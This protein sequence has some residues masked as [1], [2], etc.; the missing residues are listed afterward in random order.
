LYNKQLAGLMAIA[1]IV[2]TIL[3]GT[4]FSIK[5][6]DDVEF[7]AASMPETIRCSEQAKLVHSLDFMATQDL[8]EIVIRCATLAKRPDIATETTW[9]EVCLENKEAI[10]RFLDQLQAVSGSPVYRRY[11]IETEDGTEIQVIDF[12][13]M[14]AAIG[15]NG[16]LPGCNTIYA[17]ETK[18]GGNVSLYRGVR[19]FF[20]LRHD[21]ITEIECS[22][23]DGTSSFRSPS[24]GSQAVGYPPI[25]DAPMGKMHV[26]N[27]S[28]GDRVHLEVHF[29]TQKLPNYRIVAETPFCHDGIIRLVTVDTGEDEPSIRIDRV[30]PE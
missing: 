20:F 17:V 5:E 4:M 24:M 10:E 27:L 28:S 16:L 21:T 8:P 29:D 3:V 11:E 19:D 30:Q 15:G 26:H 2:S 12:S 9:N 7:L 25:S 23:P 18:P 13:E 6:E 1:L 22:S 14:M